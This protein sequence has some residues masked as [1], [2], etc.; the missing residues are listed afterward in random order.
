MESSVIIK[1]SRDGTRLSF[2]DV[3]GESFSAQIESTHFSGSVVASTYHCG[4]PSLLFNEIA[5]E[6]RGWEGEKSWACLEDELRL[7]A[8]ADSTGHIELEVVMRNYCDPSNWLLK[9]TLALEAG[10][11]EFLATA[12]GDVFSRGRSASL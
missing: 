7:T 2:S 10:Q 4:P 12:V 8:K 6:W 3:S 11:L 5:R 9:A 1:S